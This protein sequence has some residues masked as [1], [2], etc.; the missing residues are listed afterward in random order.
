MVG[1]V[2]LPTTKSPA[3]TEQAKTSRSK[4]EKMESKKIYVFKYKMNGTYHLADGTTQQDTS[5]WG[6]KVH[7]YI[8]FAI[9]EDEA[10][11]MFTIKVK[12]KLDAVTTTGTM[13]R[14]K[15]KYRLTQKVE[16]KTMDIYEK[17]ETKNY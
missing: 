5:E 14:G 6:D 4:D 9:N 11:R 10:D 13:R 17:I 3:L 7:T 16:L 15:I 1:T 8:A 12:Y 2:T